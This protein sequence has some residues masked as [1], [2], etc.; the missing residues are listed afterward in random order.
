M[1]QLERGLGKVLFVD[2]AYR[3]GQ[4]KFAQEAVDEL[5]DNITKPKFAGKLVVILA[6][7]EED[8]NNLLRVNQGLS[9]R[10][11]EEISFPS[12]SPVYCLQ[13]LEN[14]LKQSQI[15]FPSM[16]DSTIFQEFLRKMEALSILPSWGN[17]R[18][19][20]TLAKGMVRAVYQS[21]TTKVNQLQLSA[22]TAINCI[23]N[24]LAERCAR[25]KVVS[26]SQNSFS[27]PVDRKSVV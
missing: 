19:V 14:T 4:G 27:E 20:Q 17:A 22:N 8:M 12:L 15:A 21:N 26:P 3:L 23:N 16:E 1:K 7:Y 2:E 18:D 5:V 11:G 24:M 10:F 6:G 13:L 25:A 9:S